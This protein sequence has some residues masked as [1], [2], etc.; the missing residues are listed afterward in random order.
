MMSVFLMYTGRLEVS[1]NA[2]NF[3]SH[4]INIVLVCTLENGGS[5]C[6]DLLPEM[7]LRCFFQLGL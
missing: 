1:D 6:L 5:D 7:Y 3:F 2:S 4:Y